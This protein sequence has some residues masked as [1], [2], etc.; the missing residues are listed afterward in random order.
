MNPGH[1]FPQLPQR[2]VFKQAKS[3]VAHPGAMDVDPPVQTYNGKERSLEKTQ[4]L[5][6]GS[7]R[8]AVPSSKERL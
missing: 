8:L 6:K 5:D 2:P 7:V 3:K 1:L 4:E